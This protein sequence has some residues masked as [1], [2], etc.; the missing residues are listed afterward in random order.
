MRE[1]IERINKRIG[2]SPGKFP[3]FKQTKMSV[4]LKKKSPKAERVKKKM[5][6]EPETNK[7]NLQGA[8]NSPL[9]GDIDQPGPPNIT[10]MGPG[11]VPEA[12]GGL[13]KWRKG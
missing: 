11:P 12:R 10:S 6:P 1:K 7:K 8:I 3:G 13:G 4:Y 5:K 2:N 9:L